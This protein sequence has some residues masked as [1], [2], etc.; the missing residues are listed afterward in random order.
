[1]INHVLF[2]ASLFFVV[3]TVGLMYAPI[4]YAQTEKN[5]A[6]EISEALQKSETAKKLKQEVGLLKEAFGIE[7]KKEEKS[8]SNTNSSGGKTIADVADSALQ[9]TKGL[10]VSISETLQK[11]APNVWRI[12]IKQQ[13]VKAV[14]GVL[15]PWGIFFVFFVYMKVLRNKWVLQERCSVEE[16]TTKLIIAIIIPIIVCVGS[17]IVGVCS[18][19]NAF[20]YIINPEFYAIKDLLVMLLGSGS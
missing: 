19:A 9:L 6:E 5:S 12:M 4:S 3:V 14:S 20:K 8:S 16:R 2:K 17:G 15:I 13:Y 11:V 18:I 1:M 10:V 7:T